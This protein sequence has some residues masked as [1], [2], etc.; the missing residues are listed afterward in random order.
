M[1]LPKTAVRATGTDLWLHFVD[2]AEDEQESIGFVLRVSA[3][4]GAGNKSA[5]VHVAVSHE[6]SGGSCAFGRNGVRWGW[7][8]VAVAGTMMWRRRL[9]R[10][11]MTS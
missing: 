3:V 4:D 9:G 7:A 5:P 8:I 10:R 11:S 1:T 2:G 6:G